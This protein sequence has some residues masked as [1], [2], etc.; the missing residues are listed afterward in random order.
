MSVRTIM[1]TC[2]YG[3]G[4]HTDNC[5]LRDLPAAPG[6]DLACALL[7]ELAATFDESPAKLGNGR[8][9]SAAFERAV[10]AGRRLAVHG[11]TVQS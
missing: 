8:R 1:G 2:C 11:C 9:Y 6:A 3:E 10:E 7:V 5:P 4:E